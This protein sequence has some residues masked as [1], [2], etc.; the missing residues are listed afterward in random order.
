[1]G[2]DV[3]ERLNKNLYENIDPNKHNKET[4]KYKKRSFFN[5]ENRLADFIV[6][7]VSGDYSQ[8]SDAYSYIHN[9]YSLVLNLYC[10]HIIYT[11]NITN[12]TPEIIYDDRSVFD[13]ESFSVNEVI[14]YM[15]KLYKDMIDIA[16][17]DARKEKIP[18]SR[19]ENLE[20][21]IRSALLP[22]LRWRGKNKICK[23]DSGKSNMAKLYAVNCEVPIFTKEI[24][25][26]LFAE[27]TEGLIKEFDS[28][29][30]KREPGF[31]YIGKCQNI[32][33]EKYFIKE[34]RAQEYCSPRCSNI[35]RH[36]V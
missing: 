34:H 2:K 24:A 28:T 10:K 14:S 8:Y 36:R 12:T 7:F 32:D 17:L 27:V 6:P 13:E 3:N 1:M 23:Y 22:S 18:E 33:C 16:F 15:K 19:S 5:D 29:T 31:G 25:K 20:A 35:Q 9:D 30:K 4:K 26:N 11:Y 21:Q